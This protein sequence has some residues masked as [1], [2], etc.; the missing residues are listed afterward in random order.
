MHK[1]INVLIADDDKQMRTFIKEAIYSKDYNFYEYDPFKHD[2]SIFETTFDI[3]LI[4]IFMPR[5]NGFQLKKILTKKNPFLEIIFIS[6]E[7]NEL[8]STQAVEEG[9][10]SFLTKPITI[11]Q[12][13]SSFKAA[14]H[15]RN[16][17]NNTSNKSDINICDFD[18]SKSCY[19]PLNIK[20]QI[21]TYGPLNL[22]VLITGE[23]GSGKEVVA[24]CLHKHS[25][26][27]EHNMISINC[28]ALSSSLIESEL[29]GHTSGAF[30]GA[31]KEKLGYFEIASK[32]T[33]FLDEIG[34][35]P[36]DLQ[37]KLLRV[38]DKGEFTPVGSTVSKK[39]NTRIISATNRD[40]SKMVKNGKFRSDLYYRLHGVHISLKPLRK[41]KER[42][43]FLISLF[44]KNNYSLSEEALE[45]MSNLQ[46]RGNVRE[47]KTICEILNATCTKIIT[48]DDIVSITGDPDD[49]SKDSRVPITYQ[50]FKDKIMLPKEKI[51]F[52]NMLKETRGNI[53]QVARISGLSRRY[54]Y[55]KLK[56]LDL[57]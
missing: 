19:H 52:K 14:V 17:K 27:S 28:A 9:C 45:F 49:N 8:L 36:L 31:V 50:E 5:I 53:S 40:L 22:P 7:E 23:S 15:I 44:L 10:L 42:I 16:I 57:L 30:T 33:L 12:L 13:K 41:L 55:N 3:A 6:G 39:T 21:V 1:M 51:F 4:D 46:W 56:Y 43:P 48:K 34:E 2:E 37:T 38:L 20:N 47:L 29:F 18:D 25:L 11:S 24:E 35:L 54:L 26:K 32:G